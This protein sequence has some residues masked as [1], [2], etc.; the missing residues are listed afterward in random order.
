M[1]LDCGRSVVKVL[2]LSD[3]MVVSSD[4]VCQR[5]SGESLSQGCHVLCTVFNI[6]LSNTDYLK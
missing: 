1:T 2:H 3:H 6:S 4:H 5:G